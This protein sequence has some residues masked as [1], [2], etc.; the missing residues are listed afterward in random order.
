MMYEQHI[1][2]CVVFLWYENF[3]RANV[4]NGSLGADN[5]IKVE[6]H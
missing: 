2:H 6:K 3:M 1:N 5:E 4:L